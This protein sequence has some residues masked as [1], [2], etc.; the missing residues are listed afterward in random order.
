MEM[1]DEIEITETEDDWVEVVDAI[2]A[3]S[4]QNRVTWLKDGQGKRIAAIVPVDLAEFAMR[5][6][7]ESP[8][9]LSPALRERINTWR[10]TVAHQ[11]SDA[12][13]SLLKGPFQDG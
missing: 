7:W 3:A 4:D 1:P 12:Q 13:E 10:T 5:H 8:A 9:E 6:P 2:D 11:L